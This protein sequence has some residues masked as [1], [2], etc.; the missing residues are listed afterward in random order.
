[1]REPRSHP[2]RNLAISPLQGALVQEEAPGPG[3]VF[4][5][6]GKGICLVHGSR[7]GDRHKGGERRE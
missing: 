7:F 3:G 6:A 1:M 5:L 4:R 2:V